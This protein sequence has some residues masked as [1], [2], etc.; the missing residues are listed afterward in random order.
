M[1]SSSNFFSDNRDLE[2]H[3][4]NYPWKDILSLM[5]Q[6]KDEEHCSVVEDASAIL[7]TIGALI[8]KDFAPIASKASEESPKLK[9][10]KVEEAPLIKELMQKLAEMGAMSTTVSQDFEGMGMPLMLGHTILQ[11]LSRADVSS[12]NVFAYYLGGLKILETFEGLQDFKEQIE[13]FSTGQDF[14]AM[15][16]TES[17]AGSDLSQIKSFAKKNDKGEWR[18][19]G[20]KIWITCGHAGHHFVLARSKTQ[21]EAAGL[22]GL[23]LFHVPAQ[24]KDGSKNIEVAGLEHKLGHHPVVTATIN[25]NNSLAY[26]IGKEGEGFAL[27]LHLMNHARISTASMGLGICDKVLKD[28]RSF[29]EQ[30]VTMGQAI[31]KHPMIADYLEDMQ[32]T[33]YGVR[34][35]VFECV[36]HED[37]ELQ[38]RLK[39]QKASK[40]D[41]EIFSKKV[42]HHNLQ[43]RLLTPLA[44]YFA[45]EESVRLSRMGIQIHGGT[46]FM[47]EYDVGRFH[48]DSLLL[49]IYEG[50]SQIQSLMVLKD[51]LKAVFKS[52]SKFL[53]DIA[54]IRYRL[55]S[56]RDPLKRQVIRMRYIYVQFLENLLLGALSDQMKTVVSKS[57]L[58]TLSK[59]W[60]K[61]WNPEKSLQRGLKHAERFTKVVCYMTT[62]EVLWKRI[63]QSSDEKEKTHRA[64]I[65]QIFL[66]HYE[67]RSKHLLEELRKDTPQKSVS[68]KN[69][70][71]K[72]S[73]FFS[74]ASRFI[75]SK[76]SHSTKELKG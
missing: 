57:S 35:L 55:L 66:N 23:S 27:M 33:T 9:D 21:K 5:P 64:K 65:A 7:E 46:G 11:L 38:Y 26:L 10:G 69:S 42:K 16:L 32:A 34:A 47:K 54:K 14:G 15:A 43:A 61:H 45:T 17:E 71:L 36:F 70:S 18:L 31:A 37:M 29:A 44:K 68:T 20:Q 2:F 39:L 13:A 63:Q 67:I 40:K 50:T 74:Q 73:V 59:D 76:T 72:K 51:R 60:K 3:V 52:P 28:T 4:K 49:P 12:A 58:T 75:A 6:W 24:L 19:Q 25:Y 56:E 22:K 53:Q 30:R 62:A 8:A 1:S 41:K 48:I